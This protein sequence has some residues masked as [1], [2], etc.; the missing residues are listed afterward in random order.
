LVNPH[1]FIRKSKH[2]NS[3]EAKGA[4]N[5]GKNSSLIGEDFWDKINESLIL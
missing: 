1:V 5:K 3:D 4:N 2:N